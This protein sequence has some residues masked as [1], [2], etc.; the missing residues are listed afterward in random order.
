MI[1]DVWCSDLF[2]LNLAVSGIS[3]ETAEVSGWGKGFLNNLV[4]NEQ[5]L[6]DR[7]EPTRDSL[8]LKPFEQG[9]RVIFLEYQTHFR[10]RSDTIPGPLSRPVFCGSRRGGSDK[11]SGDHPR[12]Q[13]GNKIIDQ[14]EHSAD[15]ARG[16][17]R[18]H[19]TIVSRCYMIRFVCQRKSV[20]RPTSQSGT[21]KRYDVLGCRT[22]ALKTPKG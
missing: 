10:G 12:S 22:V 14:I 11:L 9:A 21:S 8:A 15:E 19:I 2:W 16:R 17:I 1:L 5:G 13:F 18:I 20:Q 7:L 4:C 3:R 6:A